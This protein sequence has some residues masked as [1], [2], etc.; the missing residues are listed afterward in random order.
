[1][2]G[3]F[4]LWC[5]GGYKTAEKRSSRRVI[6]ISSGNFDWR[7]ANLRF[8]TH[9]KG[10]TKADQ[11][12][13]FLLFLWRGVSF[14][15]VWCHPLWRRL[16]SY[17]NSYSSFLHHH[18][19]VLFLRGY[20]PVLFLFL[21]SVT[22]LHIP[23][24]RPAADSKICTRSIE[25]RAAWFFSSQHPPNAMAGV[26]LLVNSLCSSHGTFNQA[27]SQQALLCVCGCVCVC[28]CVI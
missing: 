20:Q 21:L 3:K 5:G 27:S 8:D 1:M 14:S 13:S 4:Y 7:W 15:F 16:Q 11:T 28:V 2:P 10:Y 26:V 25:R 23:R 22:R 17:K 19:I 12:L 18:I 9:D 6:E 24:L